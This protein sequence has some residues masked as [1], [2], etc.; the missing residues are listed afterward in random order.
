VAT[1]VGRCANTST[2]RP[3]RPHGTSARSACSWTACAPTRSTKL[4]PKAT[5][6]DTGDQKWSDGDD[7]VGYD[8]TL[9]AKYDNDAKPAMRFFFDGPGWKALLADMDFTTAPPAGG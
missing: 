3:A 7:P 8:V 4:A 6:T 2:A 5:V 9:T 1:T